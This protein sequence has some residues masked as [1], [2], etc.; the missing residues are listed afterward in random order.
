MLCFEFDMKIFMIVV[1]I[2][3]VII[4]EWVEVFVVVIFFVISEVLEWFFMDKV[5]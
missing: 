5:R 3:G 2:G 4:G 1:V